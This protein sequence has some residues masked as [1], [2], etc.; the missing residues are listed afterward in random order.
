MSRNAAPS[1]LPPEALAAG[2]PA[3]TEHAVSVLESANYAVTASRSVLWEMAEIAP[4]TRFPNAVGSEVRFFFPV[5]TDEDVIEL[6][7]KCWCDLVASNAVTVSIND[8]T[9][10]RTTPSMTNASPTGTVTWTAAHSAASGQAQCLLFTVTLTRT[11]GVTPDLRL[12][13]ARL[14]ATTRAPATLLAPGE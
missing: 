14:R 8:G 1:Q 3:L 5:W 4:G 7:F 2:I 12:L 11:S 10:T 13:N 9:T 6:E